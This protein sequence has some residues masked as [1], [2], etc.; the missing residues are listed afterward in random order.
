MRVEIPIFRQITLDWQRSARE[1]QVFWAVVELLDIVTIRPI[2]I[3]QIEKELQ[4]QQREQPGGVPEKTP[5][6]TISHALA[7]LQEAGYL[8]A[9]VDERGREGL[10]VPLS[11][12]P[13][14][15]AASTP[16]ARRGST[17]VGGVISEAF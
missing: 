9:G 12:V 5:R 17:T 16:A 13:H 6:S 7:G 14:S 3:A 11:R 15:A 8:V 4:R 1:L 10:R 2:S